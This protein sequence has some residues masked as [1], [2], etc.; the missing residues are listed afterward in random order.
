MT[1][2]GCR[3]ARAAGGAPKRIGDG[4]TAV[5]GDASAFSKIG[6]RHRNEDSYA[7]WRVGNAFFAAI[8]DGLGGMGGG[9][10][11]SSHV[12]DR[13][14]TRL[15]Q[16][17]ID[18]AR[19][20]EL[21]RESHRSLELLQLRNEEDRAMA[22]TLTVMVLRGSELVAAHCG[23]TRLYLAR[24]D[25]VEQLTED[26]SEAQRLYNEGSLSLR[27]LSRYPRKYVLES[28][29]GIP[30]EPVVQEVCRSVRPGDWLVLASDGAYGLLEPCDLVEVAR[31][32]T[33]PSQFSRACLALVEAR[34]PRDNYTMVV[35]RAG[36]RHVLRG[37]RGALRRMWGGAGAVRSAA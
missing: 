33:W 25:H 4:E 8:A 12:V 15:R 26:H 14:R 3:F 24:S 28:A 11:A 5:L 18:S 13:L 23:D 29:L 1:D 37:L 27:D 32:A 34:G 30:G 20:A 7:F 6:T 19:L 10:H 21:V 16:P 9:D 36:G 17:D 22:T 2:C 31:A 35:V